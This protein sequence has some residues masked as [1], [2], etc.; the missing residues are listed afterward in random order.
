VHDTEMPEEMV[1][2]FDDFRRFRVR[3]NEWL[4]SMRQRVRLYEVWYKVPAYAVVLRM[5]PT[6]V[7]LYD[8]KNPLHQQAVARGLVKVERVLTRQVR[9]AIF[10]GPYRL[11]DEGTTRRNFPYVPF[12]AFRDDQD[13][14]PYGLIEGMIAPQDEYNERRLRIQWLLKARQIL[15]D[16][17]ALDAKY[18]NYEDLAD[19]AQRPDMVLVRNAARRNANGVE[20][21]SNFSLQKEQVEVMQDAKNLIQDVSGV[22]PVQMGQ[23]QSGVT[24]GVAIAGLVE[25]GIV[26]M[27]ELNDN[28]RNSRRMVFENLMDLIVDDHSAAELRVMIG[29]A[30]S[31]RVVVLNTFD[32]QGMPVN[33]VKDAPIRMGMSD[34]PNSPAA[35]MQQQTQISEIIKSLGNMPQAVAVL[36]PPFLESSALDTETRRQAAEDFRKVM[37]LPAGGDKQARLE[38]DKAAAAAAQEAKA[39]QQQAQQAELDEQRAKVAKLVSAAELDVAKVEEIR[40]RIEQQEQSINDA[41]AEADAPGANA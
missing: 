36:V 16:N 17:D 40:A 20:I 28:Y 39:V 14:S 2:A 26:A 18:N 6:R 8:S 29:E 3:S 5:G 24:A 31:R 11:T 30:S 25:Q 32:P 7:I 33:M 15:V 10:A 27:G 13:S 9:K 19:E 37:G 4:D 23:A 41:L 38:A 1:R 12:F 21:M 34:V 22:Y 35:R